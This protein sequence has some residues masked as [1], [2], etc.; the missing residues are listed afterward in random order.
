MGLL[1]RVLENSMGHILFFMYSL[2]VQ[3]LVS[4]LLNFRNA[5]MKSLLAQ[6]HLKNDMRHDKSLKASFTGTQSNG[7]R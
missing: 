2:Y 7:K 4:S 5:M 6:F 3:S 1:G